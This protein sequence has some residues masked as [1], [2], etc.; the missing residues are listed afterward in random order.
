MGFALSPDMSKAVCRL[1]DDWIPLPEPILK[2][3]G[4]TEG[5]LLELEVIEGQMIVS[6]VEVAHADV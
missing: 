6:V 3:L 4:W 2:A 5:T 1:T